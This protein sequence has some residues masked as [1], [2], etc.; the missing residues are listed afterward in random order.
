MT[1]ESH[2]QNTSAYNRKLMAKYIPLYKYQAWYM[3]KNSFSLPRPIIYAFQM[4][5]NIFFV[6]QY[7]YRQ[8]SLR[9]KRKY[10]TGS[11]GLSS[12]VNCAKSEALRFKYRMIFCEHHAMRGESIIEINW[13]DSI[14]L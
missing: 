3:N 14:R 8:S 12:A 2:T 5:L 10:P 6:N 9:E 13:N 11:K 4:I 1:D 7:V